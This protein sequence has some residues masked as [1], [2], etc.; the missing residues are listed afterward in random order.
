MSASLFQ[1]I[2]FVI[3]YANRH[4]C[5][6]VLRPMGGATGFSEKLMKGFTYGTTATAAL[7]VLNKTHDWSKGK[8]SGKE[9]LFYNTSQ[10]FGVL[11]GANTLQVVAYSGA[12]AFLY[13]GSLTHRVDDWRDKNPDSDFVPTDLISGAETADLFIPGLT[14]AIEEV[15]KYTGGKGGHV[16]KGLAL[17][18]GLA[19]SSTSQARQL[20]QDVGAELHTTEKVTEDQV[21][22]R[23]CSAGD[24][25]APDVEHMIFALMD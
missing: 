17:G 20:L 18:W 15:S 23:L 19:N 16:A 12:S 2:R 21:Q 1:A 9:T 11:G 8:A 6:K 22:M 7:S 5:T 24:T 13:F 3:V 4:F 14:T 10:I 25:Y